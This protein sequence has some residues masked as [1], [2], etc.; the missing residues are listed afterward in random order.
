[1]RCC[2]KLVSELFG[3]FDTSV[4]CNASVCGASDRFRHFRPQ[5][6]PPSATAASD[7]YRPSG[8]S[9]HIMPLSGASGCFGFYR[10]TYKDYGRGTSPPPQSS[11]RRER[12]RLRSLTPPSPAA[13]R[14]NWSSQTSWTAHQ[15]A[16]CQGQPFVF[17]TRSA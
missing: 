5:L 3:I 12:L 10:P 1:M 13:V 14:V 15:R 4:N 9:G 16:R 17:P 7:H 6:A 2:V 11:G 8:A